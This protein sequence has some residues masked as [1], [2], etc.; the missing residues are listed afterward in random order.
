MKT[1]VKDIPDSYLKLVKRMP[2]VSIRTEKQYDAVLAFLEKLAIRG[3]SDFD[4]GEKDYFD[5][6]AQLAEDYEREHY[7]EE[8]DRICNSMKPLEALKFLMKEN[9]M[10]PIDLG[11]LLGNRSLASQILNGTRSLSKT[12]IRIL[13]DRFKVEPGLFLE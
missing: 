7:S 11:K 2:L 9:D 13:S 8:I 12:H 3:E 6:L 4:E 1:M 10:K 5:T